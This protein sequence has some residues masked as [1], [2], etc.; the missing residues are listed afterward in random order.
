MTS[1]WKLTE[2]RLLGRTICTVAPAK[3]ILQTL[4]DRNEDTM[5]ANLVDSDAG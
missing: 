5:L 2:Y 4:W 1:V 3:Q